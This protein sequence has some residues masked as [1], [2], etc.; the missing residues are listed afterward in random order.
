[1]HCT[2]VYFHFPKS[3]LAA[4]LPATSQ[5]FAPAA[6]PLHDLVGLSRAYGQSHDCGRQYVQACLLIHVSRQPQS[7]LRLRLGFELHHP[8]GHPLRRTSTVVRD[9]PP[10]YGVEYQRPWLHG[11]RLDIAVISMERIR[12]VAIEVE[13]G[14]RGLLDIPMIQPV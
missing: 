10:E 5:L 7:V 6:Q 8:A 12:D 4:F 14:P 1:M 9:G 3:F 2:S 11:K 13:A